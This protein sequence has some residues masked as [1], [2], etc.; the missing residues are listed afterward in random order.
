MPHG[1]DKKYPAAH[2]QWIWQYLFPASSLYTDL[3]TGITR[4]HHIHE[5]ALQKSIRAALK[6]SK[7]EK[8]VTPHTLRQRAAC[9]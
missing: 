6:L 1:L 4:R 3:E 7:V 8:R 9:L 2:K 5:T